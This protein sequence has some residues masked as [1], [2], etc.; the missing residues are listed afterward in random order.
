MLMDEPPSQTVGMVVAQVMSSMKDRRVWVL[1]NYR[2]ID[3][4]YR[5]HRINHGVV[6]DTTDECQTEYDSEPGNDES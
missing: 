1:G 6:V 5:Y 2:Y 4:W 3:R